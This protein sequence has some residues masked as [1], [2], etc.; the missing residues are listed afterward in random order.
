MNKEDLKSEIIAGKLVCPD[1]DTWHKFYRLLQSNIS[2]P[3]PATFG[4]TGIYLVNNFQKNSRFRE[5]LDTA[6]KNNFENEAYTFLL[7]SNIDLWITSTK[8]LDP[9]NTTWW[10]KNTENETEHWRKQRLLSKDAIQNLFVDQEAD[11]SEAEDMFDSFGI[12]DQL[13][14]PKQA[15]ELIEK[16][17]FP[18]K[19]KDSLSKLYQ[20][21]Y[22]QIDHEHGVDSLGMFLIYVIDIKE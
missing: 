8:K 7:N 10:V 15:S 5:Q 19:T 9:E 17:I 16:S 4:P 22:D 18:S 21:Y 6:A 2:H 12:I 14:D 3:I 11:W 13:H 1:L 20:L